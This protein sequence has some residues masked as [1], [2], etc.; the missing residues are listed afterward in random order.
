MSVTA[1]QINY[2][3]DSVKNVFSKV[4][5]DNLYQV[6][7]PFGLYGNWLKGTDL[8]NTLFQND[9][10]D[11]FVKFGLLCF[12]AELPGTQFET[13]EV[14]GDRQGLRE[15]FPSIRTYPPLN[16]SFYVDSNHIILQILETW[17]NYINPVNDTTKL[18]NVFSRL[19]Y[20]DSYK[21]KIEIVKFEK[22]TAYNEQRSDILSLYKTDMLKYEFTNVW[23]INVTSMN[24]S[25]GNA[26]VLK[27]SVQFQYDRYYVSNVKTSGYEIPLINADNIINN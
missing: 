23:P 1:T 26:D 25:Y 12:Q 7:M 8:Y 21:E 15:V 16:L 9:G 27:V 14:V 20:P 18:D 22:D 17:M 2:T 3:I 24:V 13:V 4:S 5:H 11:V 6:I 19:R 10:F